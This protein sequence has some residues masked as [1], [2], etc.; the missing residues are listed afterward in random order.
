MLYNIYFIKTAKCATESIRSYLKEYSNN[1]GLT[2]NDYKFNS[3][4]LKKKFNINTNHIWANEKSYNHFNKCKDVNL[5]SLKISSVRNPIERLYSHYCFGHPS[6][7]NGIDF[8]EWYLRVSRSEISDG[9]VVPEWGDMTNN[10]MWNYMGLQSLDDLETFD[11]IFIKEKFT[12]S[13]NKFSN[14]IEYSFEERPQKNVNPYSIK[15]YKFT[16]EVISIFEKNNQKDISLYNKVLN[17]FN[18]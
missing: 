9:W 2:I 4:F 6:F 16:D 5:P 11:F 10:Y 13:L 12:E 8:N 18:K 15:D 17:D 14:L 3:F 1:T 7:K